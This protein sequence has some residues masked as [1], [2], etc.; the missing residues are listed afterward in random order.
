MCGCKGG[1]D[2]NHDI[3]YTRRKLVYVENRPKQNI[4][5]KY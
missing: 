2:T 4:N 1:E 3:Y 5:K